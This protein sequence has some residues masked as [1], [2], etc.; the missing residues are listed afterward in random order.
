[1][2]SLLACTSQVDESSAGTAVLQ[3]YSP[4]YIC[5]KTVQFQSQLQDW[6]NVGRGCKGLVVMDGALLHALHAPKCGL[7]CDRG[8]ARNIPTGSIRPRVDRT[9]GSAEGL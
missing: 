4:Q 1:M 3:E 6:I 5:L 8:T 9:A 7:R 2:M